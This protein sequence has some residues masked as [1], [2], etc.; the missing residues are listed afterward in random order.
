MTT[1][2]SLRSLLA[3]QCRPMLFAMLLSAS[4]S[5]LALLQPLIAGHI[6]DTAIRGG[7]LLQAAGLLA[8]AFIARIG[9]EAA[10]R[11]QLERIGE[12]IIFGQRKRYAT[13]V[14]HLPV[15]ELDTQ[16]IG[17]LV[18]RGSADTSS[19]R[20]LPRS[21]NNMA[22]MLSVDRLLVAIVLPFVTGAFLASN[23][24][25]RKMQDAAEERQTYIG[26][27]AACLVDQ[28]FGQ[29]STTSLVTLSRKRFS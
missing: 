9:I 18:S 15:A 14:L 24:V 4:G 23:A 20:E 5:I 22:L 29:I 11:F 25:L 27:Y 16:R 19:L 12:R 10:S 26:L 21:L 13:H 1:I 7:R 28:G 6:V 2:T 3:G 8:A 17:D